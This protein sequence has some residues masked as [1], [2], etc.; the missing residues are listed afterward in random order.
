MKVCKKDA[1]VDPFVFPIQCALHYHPLPH[2]KL[3]RPTLYQWCQ[4]PGSEV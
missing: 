4:K 1:T 2:N 3:V